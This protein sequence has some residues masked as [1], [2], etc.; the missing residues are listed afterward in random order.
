MVQVNVEEP[1][2]DSLAC[3]AGN[4]I[5]FM[6]SLDMLSPHEVKN[7]NWNKKYY[8][9]S[10]NKKAV[11]SYLTEERVKIITNIL[12][13]PNADVVVLFRAK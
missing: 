7:G 12:G 11:D 9:R 8:I 1:F 4:V 13:M 10:Q 6:Q 5:T 2:V 3:G